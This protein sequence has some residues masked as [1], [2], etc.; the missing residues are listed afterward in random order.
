MN[1]IFIV[2]IYALEDKIRPNFFGPPLFPLELKEVSSNLG[3]EKYFSTKTKALNYL[4][5]KIK[6][7]DKKDVENIVYFQISS[8]ELDSNNSLSCELFDLNFK[9][10]IDYD[11]MDKPF[12]GI[13]KESKY[14]VGDWII[15]IENQQVH[16]GIIGATPWTSEEVKKLKLTDLDQYENAYYVLWDNYRVSTDEHAHSHLNEKL[17]LKK[18]TKIEEYLVVISRNKL[19]ARFKEY[20]DYHNKRF[21]IKGK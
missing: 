13:K 10:I 9:K 15:F 6:E 12:Y 7:Q 17:I 4:K 5:K 14:K 3:C 8:V 20:V 1:S 2:E 16:C 18:V 21:S 19:E 11:G